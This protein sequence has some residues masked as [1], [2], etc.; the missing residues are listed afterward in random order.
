MTWRLIWL[1]RNEATL[2]AMFQLLVLYKYRFERSY[3]VILPLKLYL[4]VSK[5][6]YW[7]LAIDLKL[8]CVYIEFHTVFSNIL[9]D[10][11]IHNLADADEQEVVHQIQV[12]L[13]PTKNC[14]ALLKNFWLIFYFTVFHFSY[15]EK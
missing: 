8:L 10:T 4:N 9:K 13:S 12:T 2:N 7:L 5:F 1:N 15:S 6:H 3:N 11:Q 14:F